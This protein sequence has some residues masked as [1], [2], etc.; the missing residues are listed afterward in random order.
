MTVPL[1]GSG[2]AFSR[3]GTVW[4]LMDDLNALRGGPATTRVLSGANAT[5]RAATILAAY[6]AGTGIQSVS[7]GFYSNLSAWQGTATA[8]LTALKSLCQA[9]V[10]RMVDLDSPLPV[11]DLPSALAVLVQQMAAA[12]ATVNASVPAAA[13]PA[14]VGTPNGTLTIV[15]SVKN[16][17]GQ[18]LQY[19]LPE[20]LT[21]TCTGDSQSGSTLGNEPL[22]VKGAG[23]V[24][25]TLAYT[26]PGGSG[27]SLNFKAVDGTKNN[28]TGN[29]LQNSSF[30]VFS[31]AN[32]PDNWTLAIGAA[33]TDVFNGGSGN[34]YSG[35]GS[36]Q[37]TGTGA[38]LLDA[39]TQQ[40]GTSP[41]ATV[42]A[43]GTAATLLP[44][45]QYAFSGW[46]KVSA[47]PTA[48]VLE[49]ALIDGAGATLNDDAGTANAVT[50]SLTA[51]T[52]TWQPVS[53]VFRTPAVLPSTA[54][55]RVRL[56]TAI[57]SGVSVFVDRLALAAMNQVYAGG[58]YLAAFSGANKLITGDT[59][60]LAMTNTF[61]AVQK[62]AEMVFG[63]RALGLQFPNTTSSPTVA[64]SV[65]A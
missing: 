10:I 60:L 27:A 43:G 1:T 61:G 34:A 41:T 4:A 50:Q 25:D 53:G 18:N 5:T 33:G 63:M 36:L 30:E 51:V 13:A 59:W 40:F 12:P 32:V 64:D 2:G 56:S 31:T 22:S 49:F 28:S 44:D 16:T 35:S 26:W 46:I 38:A 6:A 52:S 9:T 14:A 65:I 23:A 62:R 58:L 45:T 3:L 17:K 19:L 47:T 37:F 29:L 48:G 7:D 24:A 21:L 15:V 11:K 55:L 20:T 57:D 54:K 39:V 42:G 8:F